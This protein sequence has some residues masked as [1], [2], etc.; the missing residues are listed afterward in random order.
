MRAAP[1]RSRPSRR[2]PLRGAPAAAPALRRAALAAAPPPAPASL[3]PSFAPSSF[4]NQ[5]PSSPNGASPASDLDA[6]AKLAPEAAAGRAIAD[7]PP[8]RARRLGEPLGGLG[9][10]EP[11]LVAGEQA[12]LARLGERHPP[13]DQQRLDRGQRGSHRLGDLRVGEVVDLAQD[14][15]GPLR[16]GKLLHVGDD[17]AQL[18]PLLD[19]LE[20]GGPVLVRM[21]VHRVLAL[22][23]RPPQVVQAAVAGDPVEPR[24]GGDRPLVGEHRRVGGDE[25]LLEHVLRVLLRVEQVPAEGEQAGLVAVEQDLEGPIVPV[26]NQSD[27][28]LV[29][30][31]PKQRRTPRQQPAMTRR[32]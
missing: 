28:P 32:L 22:G 18:L 11:H 5:R 14:H 13:P 9:E 4:W 20:R 29:A 16:L 6:G 24:P 7:V 19:L 23:D 10:L 17:L 15:R 3:P 8:R 25:D 31:Q 27:E 1:P 21:D 12:R 26:A 2:P 30:L